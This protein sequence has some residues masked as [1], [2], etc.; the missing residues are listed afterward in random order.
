MEAKRNRAKALWFLKKS[1]I[2]LPTVHVFLQKLL[3]NN[4][5]LFLVRTYIVDNIE[6][7]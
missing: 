7:S 3:G 5:D 6:C 2:D 4:F 1:T